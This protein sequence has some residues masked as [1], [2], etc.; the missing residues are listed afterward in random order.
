[1]KVLHIIPSA[2]DYFNDIRA[3]AFSLVGKLPGFGI[4]ADAFT[5]QYGSASREER[6][7]VAAKAPTQHFLGLT[8]V[9]ELIV[10]LND[11]DL[12]HM[13][14]PFLGAAGKIIT[15]KREHPKIPL[16]ATFHRRVITPDF[17]SLGIVWYNRY[18]LPRLFAVAD[19]ITTPEIEIFQKSFGTALITDG[20][21]YEVDDST[22]WFGDNL[23][24]A[25]DD[26]DDVFALKYALL[27]TN[28]V[29][30]L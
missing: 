24:N 14:C 28:L 2:F 17:F 5:L 3:T 22:N 29:K 25:P 27:Y 8:S 1:M 15:W 9:A 10:A 30:N 19:A 7:E 13:H 20:K 23:P 16:V 18:Y 12:V 11:Y 6:G 21:F 4:E 26:P